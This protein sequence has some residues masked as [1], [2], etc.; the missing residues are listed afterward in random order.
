M[1]T[2]APSKPSDT[3]AKVV[4]WSAALSMAIAAALVASVHEVNPTVQ[5]KFSFVTVIAFFAA[6]A[7]TVAFFRIVFRPAPSDDAS[8]AHAYRQR[9]LLFSIVGAIAMIA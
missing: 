6:G 3:L 9:L 5:F 4:T 7:I 1:K 2:P 8:A